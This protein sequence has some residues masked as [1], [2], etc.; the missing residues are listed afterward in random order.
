[1]TDSPKKKGMPSPIQKMEHDAASNI[2]TIWYASQY[3]KLERV[4]SI[5]DRN[6]VASIDVQEFRTRWSPLHFACRY[7]HSSVVELLVARGANVDLPDWQGNTPLH[8]AAGWGDLQCVTLVLEGGADVRRKNVNNNTPLDLAISLFRKDHV[9]LLKD[10]KPLGLSAEELA[11]YRQHLIDNDT[12]IK[13]FERALA[14]EPNPDIRLELQALHFKRKCFGVNHPGLLGTFSKLVNLYREDKKLENAFAMADCGLT[15]C[16]ATH[17]RCHLE[18]ARW[19]STLAELLLQREDF[20]Q[21]I[22]CFVEALN[23]LT[24]LKG[25]ADQETSVALENLAIGCQQA[26][27]LEDTEKH[28]KMLLRLLTERYGGGYNAKLFHLSV[29]L[30]SVLLAKKRT[31]EARDLFEQCLLHAENLFGSTD[32]HTVTCTDALG[33]CCFLLGDFP[34]AEM[35]FKRSLAVIMRLPNPSTTETPLSPSRQDQFRRV[36]SNLAMVAI[37]ARSSEAVHS[38]LEHLGYMN[39]ESGAPQTVATML[40]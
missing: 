34:E 37:A 20:D 28:L 1:M 29:Q 39:A 7:G 21:A 16:E 38:Q 8:L 31:N 15:L 24:T 32:E 3:G 27:R 30:A 10:W 19:V 14:E 40:K 22:H 13:E 5:L 6:A 12:I 35:Y 4:R 26:G 9:C 2:W 23:T 18:T 33:K 25:E 11:E 17:G 36:Q